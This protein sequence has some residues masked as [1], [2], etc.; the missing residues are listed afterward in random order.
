MKIISYIVPVYNAEKYLSQ[1]IESILSQKST[2]IELILVDDGSTDGSLQICNEY[3]AKDSRVVVIHKENGGVSSA[4]NKGLEAAHGK[5]IRFIDSD[6]KI[7]EN[8]EIALV[9]NNTSDWIIGGA[10]VLNENETVVRKLSFYDVG[11]YKPCMLL[12]KMDCSTKKLILHYVWNHFYKREIIEIGKLRFDEAISL[13]EDFLFNISYFNMCCSIQ[14]ISTNICCYYKRGNACLTGVFK[15][16]EL[17]RRRKMDNA[18]LS[19]YGNNGLLE[20][21]KNILNLMLGE[22]AFVS[23]LKVR[24]PLPKKTY[25][26]R[27]LFICQMF[28][29]EYQQ[30]ILTY[31]SSDTCKGFS[32][33]VE[34]FLIKL[35]LKRLFYMFEKLKYKFS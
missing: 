15:K 2:D 16:D 3:K 31:L 32:K 30:L 26:E 34:R 11:V 25:R 7:G 6:D 9:K 21:K 4:R 19:L 17:S 5:Y 1:C 18:L 10:L 27:L 14:C 29:S 24:L 35:K 8:D 23:L 12:Y 22:I 20:K 33:G 28:D 13:G